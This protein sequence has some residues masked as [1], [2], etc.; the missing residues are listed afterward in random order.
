MVGGNINAGGDGRVWHKNIP[1]T[2]ENGVDS[3]D[4]ELAELNTNTSNA[5]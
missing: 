2:T 1:Q 3:T 5:G 4:L